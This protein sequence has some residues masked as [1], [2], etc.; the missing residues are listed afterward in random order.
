MVVWG[1]GPTGKSFARALCGEGAQIRAFVDMDP[2]KIGQE[3]H[4][5]PV[6]SPVAVADH[7]DAFCVA[8]VDQPRARTEIWASLARMGWREGTD[9]VAVA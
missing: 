4:G 8:T 5:A 3:I 2:R 9:F 1:A 6:I 7:S